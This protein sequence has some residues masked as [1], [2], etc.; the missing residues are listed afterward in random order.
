MQTLRRPETAQ[1]RL[2]FWESGSSDLDLTA[3]PL[4]DEEARRIRGQNYFSVLFELLDLYAEATA[5]EGGDR[6]DTRVFAMAR[7]LLDTLP[8][9][10]ALPEV[11]L[12]PDGEI[13]FDW[14]RPDR[15]ML[16]VSIGPTRS[17]SYAARL[18]DRTA[19]GVIIVGDGFPLALTQLLRS[20]Y[21]PA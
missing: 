15:T 4:V 13:A 20:L 2:G 3:D 5:E 11:G 16:S 7:D 9:G 17:L 21:Y 10:F 8:H 6:V 19:H 18:R 14:I 1:G 12:D